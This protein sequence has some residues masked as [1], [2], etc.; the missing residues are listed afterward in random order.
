MRAAQGTNRKSSVHL[1]V[2]YWNKAAAFVAGSF[3]RFRLIRRFDYPYLIN[4][5]QRARL[6]NRLAAGYGK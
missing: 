2:S 5:H 3:V 4:P 6:K 1:A